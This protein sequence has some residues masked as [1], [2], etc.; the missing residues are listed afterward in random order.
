M[1]GKIVQFPIIVV[2]FSYVVNLLVKGIESGYDS[3]ETEPLV[4]NGVD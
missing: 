4:V 3:C 2:M 1:I